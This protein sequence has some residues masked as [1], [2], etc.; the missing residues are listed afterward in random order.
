VLD[1]V[2]RDDPEGRVV[3]H[4]ETDRA[5]ALAEATGVG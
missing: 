1:A 4:V 5:A 2:L 3:I